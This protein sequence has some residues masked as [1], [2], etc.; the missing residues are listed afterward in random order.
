MAS[1]NRSRRSNRRSRG[2]R[3]LRD[4]PRRLVLTVAGVVVL[5]AAL[6]FSWEAYRAIGALQDA[7]DRAEVLKQNIVDGDVA[8]ARRSLIR[9]DESTSRAHGSTDGPLWWLGAQVPFVG[10]NVDAVR[11][12]S[13]ALDQVSD[14][15]LPGIVD[16]ADKVRLETFRPKNG[17]MNMAEVAA[18]APVLVKADAV[19]ARSDREVGSFDANGLIGP[20]RAPMTALQTRF[21]HTA[22]AAAAAND[23]AKLLPTM[24]G[25]DGTK[26]R[27]L[28]LIMNNAEVR[29]LAGMPGSIAVITAKNGKIKMGQQGGI[30]DIRPLGRPLLKLTRDEKTVF[31]SSVATDMR[32]TALDPDFPR[33]GELAASVVG[34]RLKVNFDG[35]VAIDPVGLGYVLKGIGPVDVGDNLT[36]NVNNAVSTLLNLVYLKYPTNPG[37]Q[38][39]VFEAAARHIFDATV[40]GTGNSQSVIRA[41]VQSVTERRLML[42]SRDQTEQKR[43]RSS[44]ISGALNSGSGRP[45]VGVFVNDNGSTKLEYY[46]SM[47]TTVRSE[48]CLAGDAQELRVT[49]TLTSRAPANASRLPPSIVNKGVWVRPGNMLLGTMV[50]GPLGGE[51]TSMTVDGQRAPVGGAK[52]AGR[53]VAKIARELPPGQS[54]V[55]VTT[56]R[57]AVASPGDPELRTTPGVLPS[58]DQAGTSACQ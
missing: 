42:W 22:T 58:E 29:S 10:R 25:A 35:V 55:I 14:E 33:A 3:G 2:L 54:S 39:D 24:M 49:T 6:L 1:R 48:R 11:T 44:G 18:A 15:V 28:L 9:L 23:A 46:L 52:L 13:R 56:M 40:D 7:D 32:D 53:P 31:Q 43:I 27:Y 45:Q 34:K 36:I 26:R 50:F 37:K 5:G 4:D 57:T 16:V 21:S 47:G 38:D 41:L 19:F 20:L 8:A 17:Q 30:H 12:V 51:I